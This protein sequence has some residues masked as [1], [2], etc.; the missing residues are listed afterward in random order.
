MG[1]HLSVRM[2]KYQMVISCDYK[3]IGVSH[4]IDQ[5]TDHRF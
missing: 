1:K 4:E 5:I 3:I 2:Y